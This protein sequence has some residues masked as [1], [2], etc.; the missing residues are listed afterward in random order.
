MDFSAIV[1]L[2]ALKRLDSEVNC[3]SHVT[4]ASGTAW[5]QGQL[6]FTGA[7]MVLT[8]KLISLASAYQ[9]GLRSDQVLVPFSCNAERLA[10]RSLAA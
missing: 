2:L 7:Q 1:I 3:C 9:D 5:K 6:D 4:A 10:K 8:L